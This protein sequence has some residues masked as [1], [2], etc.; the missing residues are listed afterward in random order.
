MSVDTV[1]IAEVERILGYTFNDPAL[2]ITALTHKSYANEHRTECNGRLEYLGDSV[3]NLVVAERL[4]RARP[5]EEGVLTELRQHI[6]SRVPLAVAVRNMGLLSYYRLG[7]GAKE[8]IE[9]FGIKPTSDIFEAAL[10]AI[11]LD[12]GMDSARKFVE[13]HL[14]TVMAEQCIA[15]N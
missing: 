6:V 11:Y 4:F 2:L 3:L 7:K 15:Q 13:E 14:L 10:G 9:G 1:N 12:G 8:G 5:D